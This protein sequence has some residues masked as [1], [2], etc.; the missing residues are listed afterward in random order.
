MLT[1]LRQGQW[2][3]NFFDGQ[4][5]AVQAFR[6]AE[7]ENWNKLKGNRTGPEYMQVDMLVLRW[8]YRRVF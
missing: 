7:V 1:S 6:K 3:G 8:R 5:Q 4:T 2:V